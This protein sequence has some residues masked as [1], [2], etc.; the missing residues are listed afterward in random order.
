MALIWGEAELC[1]LYVCLAKGK[2]D[3]EK[4]SE[5]VTYSDPIVTRVSFQKNQ[6]GNCLSV[7]KKSVTKYGKNCSK[8]CYLWPKLL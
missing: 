2:V 3:K 8:K 6:S 5:I 7:S 1:L 4:K